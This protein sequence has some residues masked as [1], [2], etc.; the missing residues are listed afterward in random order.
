MRSTVTTCPALRL[1]GLGRRHQDV[2]RDAPVLRREEEHA[3]LGVQAADDAA[4][5]ALEHFD[6]LA[7][8]PAAMV[9]PGDA[10][11]GAVAMHELAHLGA[12]ARKIEALPSSGTRKPWPSGWPSTRPGDHRDA[13]RDQQ[14]AGA[15][16]HDLAGALERAQRALEFAPR[17]A[18]DAQPRGELVGAQRRARGVQRAEDAARVGS[19]VA[20]ASIAPSQRG[21]FGFFL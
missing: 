8:R 3:V 19:V 13:L 21:S 11:R 9:A 17:L 18:P 4:V 10:H 2:V 7:G 14:R 1:A 5:A 20:V 15:V 6:D 12:A 16:L